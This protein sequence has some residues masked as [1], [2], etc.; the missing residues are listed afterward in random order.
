MKGKGSDEVSYLAVRTTGS[1]AI[2]YHGALALT[3]LILVQSLKEM[4]SSVYYYNL[5]ALGVT[6]SV[7]VLLVFLT[8]MLA[9]PLIKKVGWRFSFIF[10][11]G[12][13]S[14]S[15]LP[16]G[17]GLSQPFH[18][19]FSCIALM[20]SSQLLVMFLALHRREREVDPDLFSSQSLTASFGIAIMVLVM[21]RIAGGGLDLTIVRKVTGMVLS[22]LFSGMISLGLGVLL[23]CIK[24]ARFLDDK[25]EENGIPG[26]TI[27]GGAADSWAPALGLGGFLVIFTSIITDPM[28]VTGWIGE[29][30]T[31]SSSFTL[32]ILGL[33]LLSLMSGLPWMMALRRWF[34]NPWGAMLG[35]LIMIAGAVNLFIIKFNVGVA[36]GP[37]VWIAMVDLWLILDAMTDNTPFAGEPFEV[38]KNDGT[39]RIIGFPRK[40]KQRSSPA[41]YG[42]IMTIA[43]GISML[44]VVLISFSLNWSFIPMGAIFKGGIPTLMVIGV[45][46]YGFY[47]F[48]CSKN[49]IPEPVMDDKRRLM[50]LKGSPTTAAQE[51]SGHLHLGDN[52]SRRLR[53]LFMAIGIATMF[54]IIS[55][56][57]MTIALYSGGVEE[58]E[59]EYGD[60]L[61]VVTYNIHHG[62]SNEGAIDPVP[63][64]EM[65]RDLEPDIVFLQEADS[66]LINQGNFDPGAYL[67]YKLSMNYY[68]GADPGLGNPGTAILS[69]FPMRELE[70]RKLTSDDIQR[71]AVTCYADLGTTEVGLINVHFGLE[72]EERAKQMEDVFDILDEMEADPEVRSI[73]LGGDFNTQPDEPMIGLLSKTLPA[74]N[75]SMTAERDYTLN[76]GWHSTPQGIADPFST[77]YPAEGLDEEEEHIDYLFFSNDLTVLDAGIEPGEGISDHRPVWARIRT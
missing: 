5:V 32:I 8:P 46:F 38:Q 30:Y 50:L 23:I 27:T 18:L 1:K 71:I 73:I 15:R 45:V 21:F 10:F 67:S 16:M 69:R 61:V 17:L 70:V 4:I 25:R 68:R 13:V 75:E 42:R 2:M 44:F 39:K 54:L 62:Y 56:G 60:E 33:F 48:S 9:A 26:Y 72:E 24:D 6:P 35:N 77:T 57:V 12:L 55:S 52:R 74:Y 29:D 47:G 7:L 43:L 58:K 3:V 37:F 36:P 31:T 76:S 14:M 20:S 59:L 19:I 64:L 65:L 22:P 40:K 63:H 28:V 53:N 51:G 34:S 41:H 11:G 49:N 66:L